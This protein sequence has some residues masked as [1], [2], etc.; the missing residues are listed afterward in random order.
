MLKTLLRR[1]RSARAF[2]L[3]EIVVVLAILVILAGSILVKLDVLQ[4]R[5]NKGVAASDMAGVSR[6]MQTYTVTNNHYPDGFDSLID[7]VGNPASPGTPL[8]A[9]ELYG[10]SRTYP[11]ADGEASLDP[12]L[13]GLGQGNPAKLALGTLTAGEIRSLNRMGIT[14]LFDADAGSPY[15]ALGGFP[16]DHFNQARLLQT[17]DQVAIVNATLNGSA[18]N[19]GDAVAIMEHF[20]P[21]SAVPGTPPSGTRVVVFGLGPRCTLVGRSGMLQTAPLYANSSDRNKYYARELVAFEISDG[22]SRA[23]FLG[24]LGADADRLDEEITEYYEIQ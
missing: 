3:L 12:Q 2:T 6:I 20:Y 5:A 17:G 13:I 8:T 23:R 14:T 22:G 21:Q 18:S 19:D 1:R 7:R 15:A 10:V 16:S 9:G 24:A 11:L 4:L